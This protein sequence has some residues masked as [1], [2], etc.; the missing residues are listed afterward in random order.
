MNR[1]IITVNGQ[2]KVTLIS[3]DELE[4]LE[5][6]AEV[7]SIPGAKKSIAEGTRQAKRNEGISLADL[8]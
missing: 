2:P 6:T 7:L 3:A 1:V 8:K 4:S 5:E